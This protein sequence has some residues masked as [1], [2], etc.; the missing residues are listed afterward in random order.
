MTYNKE[1]T[2][3]VADKLLAKLKQRE[4]EQVRELL[5][6]FGQ[7][8]TGKLSYNDLDESLLFTGNKIKEIAYQIQEAMYDGKYSVRLKFEVVK[9][10]DE[11]SVARKI[12]G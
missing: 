3:R 5:R 7:F 12:H 6:K 10:K 4:I 1:A 2:E 8:Q 9:K 11:P